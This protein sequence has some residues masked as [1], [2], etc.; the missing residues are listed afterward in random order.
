MCI[1]YGGVG[2]YTVSL[3]DYSTFTA[4]GYEASTGLVFRLA[5]TAP[6]ITITLQNTTN[7]FIYYSNGAQAYGTSFVV[8]TGDY[9]EIGPV[10]GAWQVLNGVPASQLK[11]S[12]VP[13]NTSGS[14]GYFKN[15]YVNMSGTATYTLPSGGQYA[16]MVVTGNSNGTIGNSIG[17][18]YAGG[19][20]ISVSGQYILSGVYWRI[21]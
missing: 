1:T 13:N 21:A 3:P 9:I 5:I 10:N 4:N 6:N 2:G 14:L 17:G 11:G 20:T 16:V 18:V 15:F 12:P 8:T 19:S 7:T